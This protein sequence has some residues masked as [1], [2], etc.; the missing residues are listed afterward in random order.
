[1]WLIQI[2]SSDGNIFPVT[3]LLCGEFT[4][5]RWIPLTKASNA[6]LWCFLWSAPWINGWVNNRESQRHILATHNCA[7]HAN[8]SVMTT[9][10]WP[11]T[12]HTTMDRLERERLPLDISA[13]IG[14][15]VILV[16][17]FD[18]N[19]ACSHI[20]HHNIHRH[21]ENWHDIHQMLKSVRQFNFRN[22]H[23]IICYVFLLLMIIFIG[24]FMEPGHV[25][26]IRTCNVPE[27]AVIAVT[28]II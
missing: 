19:L 17:P 26:R 27:Y 24:V 21:L 15:W 2:T 14:G 11:N 7:Q 4:D 5:H 13:E 16:T 10:R 23:W 3:G 22:E 25:I 28:Q 1:M 9:A 12:P 8:H 20:R 6:E 18:T